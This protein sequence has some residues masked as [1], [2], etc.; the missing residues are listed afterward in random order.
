VFY[1]FINENAAIWNY[2]EEKPFFD[3]HSKNIKSKGIVLIKTPD[4]VLS[5][6]DVPTPKENSGD[7]YCRHDIF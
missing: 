2:Y 3:R 4:R 5:K 6:P 1:Y 7:Q